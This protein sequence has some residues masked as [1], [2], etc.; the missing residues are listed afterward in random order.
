MALNAF[1]RETLEEGPYHSVSARKRIMRTELEIKALL[2]R[3][4]ELRVIMQDE[5]SLTPVS[6]MGC[7][8][9]IDTYTVFKETHRPIPT[10]D[11]A[12][13]IHSRRIGGHTQ[14]S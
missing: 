12:F 3:L 1:L 11:R 10:T 8:L 13:A 9:L 7:C 5:V 2:N 6:G 14:S 4:A